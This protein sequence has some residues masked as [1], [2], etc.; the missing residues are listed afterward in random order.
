M[1]IV[2]PLR[3]ALSVPDM[4]TIARAQLY[5]LDQNEFIEFQFNPRGSEPGMDFGWGDDG[6]SGSD[7]V[8]TQ[9]LG[10]GQTEF[11]LASEWIVDPGA[12][13]IDHNVAE[14]CVH[15]DAAGNK[16]IMIGAVLVAFERWAAIRID[17]RRP[18]L[19]RVIWPD[20]RWYEGR[21]VRLSHRIEERF[22]SGEARRA[23][24]RMGFK[25]WRRPNTPS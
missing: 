20:N 16:L 2:I 17:S 10:Q 1:R 15:E 11:E 24:V 9:F 12:P 14:P 7:K 4:A 19:I 22:A 25:E 5:N 3:S 18:S 21:L 23:T 8:D 6:F 13:V